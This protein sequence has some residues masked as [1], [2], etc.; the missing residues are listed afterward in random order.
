MHP[1]GYLTTTCF[2]LDFNMLT[3]DWFGC[4]QAPELQPKHCKAAA[5]VENPG[6]FH[7]FALSVPML[8]PEQPKA[9]NVNFWRLTS[10]QM[11]KLNYL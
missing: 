10:M 2:L 11:K 3:R 6:V 9:S 1:C 7:P 4:Q 5:M 8:S